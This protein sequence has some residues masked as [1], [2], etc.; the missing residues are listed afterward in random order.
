M[1]YATPEPPWLVIGDLNVILSQHDK[2]RGK[3][4][5]S[6]EIKFATTLIE[7]EDSLIYGTQEMTIPCQMGN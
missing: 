2:Q 6:K 7:Q 5:D 1:Q 3:P 4:F